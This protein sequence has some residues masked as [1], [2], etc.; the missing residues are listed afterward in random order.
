MSLGV[1]FDAVYS[2]DRESFKA[3]FSTDNHVRG[4]TNTVGIEGNTCTV[5][6]K[7]INTKYAVTV[8]YDIVSDGLLEERVAF[9]KNCIITS[10]HSI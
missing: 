5:Y 3:A 4:K 7:G 9:P 2:D 6:P 10:K 1:S 8:D